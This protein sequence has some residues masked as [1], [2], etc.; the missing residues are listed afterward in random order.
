[1]RSFCNWGSQLSWLLTGVE[2]GREHVAIV[3][4]E[5]NIFPNYLVIA[6][7]VRLGKE[8]KNV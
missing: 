1:M 4:L 8:V 5:R 7:R 2:G 3:V 6:T